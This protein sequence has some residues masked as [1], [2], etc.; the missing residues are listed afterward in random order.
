ML[1]LSDV[2]F[3]IPVRLDSPARRENLP[4]CVRHLRSVADTEIIIGECGTTDAA[5][6]AAYYDTGYCIAPAPW[7]RTRLINT[8]VKLAETKYVAVLD[9]DIILLE[10]EMIGAKLEL[11][12]G[13]HIV[14]PYSRWAN[15]TRKKDFDRDLP[16]TKQRGY[17]G[18]FFA[19]RK[20]YLHVGGRISISWIGAV[21]TWNAYTVSGPWV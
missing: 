17:G 21:R 7:Y 10:P 2:T 12:L 15:I 11:D 3:V 1:D 18:V 20:A 14:Y 4:I 13:Q 16:I 5:G 9:L 19:D 6:L 8:M